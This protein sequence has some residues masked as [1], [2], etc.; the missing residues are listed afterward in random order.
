MANQAKL[1]GQYGY[2]P[3]DPGEPTRLRLLVLSRNLT[4]DRSWDLSLSLDGKVGR[5]RRPLNNPLVELVRRLP[6]MSATPL[7]LAAV[8]FTPL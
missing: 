4:R 8:E 6:S 2:R 7:C 5:G 3:L 1:E